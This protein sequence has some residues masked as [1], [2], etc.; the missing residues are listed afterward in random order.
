MRDELEQ[1]VTTIT[2]ETAELVKTDQG[3]QT[4]IRAALKIQKVQRGIFGRQKANARRHLLHDGAATEIERVARG[5]RSRAHQARRQ[6]AAA[7][8]QRCWRGR[9]ARDGLRQKQQAA[10]VVQSAFRGRKDRKAVAATRMT[11]HEALLHEGAMTLQRLCRRRFEM[12]EL[13]ARRWRRQQVLAALLVQRRFRYIRQNGNWLAACMVSRKLRA[14]GLVQKWMRSFL[15]RL[16]RRKNAQHTARMTL[17]LLEGLSKSHACPRFPWVLRLPQ[18][19]N[20]R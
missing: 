11:K 9:A 19:S 3:R 8:I 13:G 18:P 7:K 5:R 12:A 4:R 14:S 17:K 20:A 16:H 1:R 6:A 10:T 2:D 15:C